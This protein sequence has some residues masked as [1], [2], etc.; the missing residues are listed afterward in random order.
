MGAMITATKIW[1]RS[2]KDWDADKNQIKE[3]EDQAQ[4]S[5]ATFHYSLAKP[6]TCFSRE[7]ILIEWSTEVFHISI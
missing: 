3:T 7:M 1:A 4:I 6:E 2:D 5:A